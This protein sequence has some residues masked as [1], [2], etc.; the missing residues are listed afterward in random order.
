MSDQEKAMWMVCGRAADGKSTWPIC[1]HPEEIQ[2]VEH[3]E[4]AFSEGQ[5]YREAVAGKDKEEDVLRTA[6]EAHEAYDPWRSINRK[7]GDVVYLY[8]P[9]LRTAE[10]SDMD[11]WDVELREILAAE[12]T[13]QQLRLGKDA[14]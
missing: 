7:D 8:F 1:A 4:R 10:T 2:A 6:R 3:C 5:R 14:G 13:Q 11:A 12:Y 9:V